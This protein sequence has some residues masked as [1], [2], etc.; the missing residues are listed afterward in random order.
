[1]DCINMIYVEG[2]SGKRY[3]FY[4][5]KELNNLK[6]AGGVFMLTKKNK[7]DSKAC[8]EVI[9]VGETADM[10]LLSKE[11]FADSIPNAFE[12]NCYC[13]RLVDDDDLRTITYNDLKDSF[14]VDCA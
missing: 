8:Y 11:S 5:F 4:S 10:S 1:M 3:R 12:A 7:H 13:I 2:T 9:Y 6:K 14:S